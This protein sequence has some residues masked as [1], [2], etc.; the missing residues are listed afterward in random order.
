MTNSNKKSVSWV[1]D[2]YIDD[3]KYFKMNDEPNAKGLSLEEVNEI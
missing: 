2:E 1:S 3:I